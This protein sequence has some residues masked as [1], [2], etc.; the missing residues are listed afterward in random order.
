MFSFKKES[1]KNASEKFCQIHLLR[2]NNVKL[3][4]FVFVQ[5]HICNFL[6]KEG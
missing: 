1:F 2:E 3:C 6:K 4:L 5:I